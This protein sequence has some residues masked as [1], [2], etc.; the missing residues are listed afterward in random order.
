MY[1]YIESRHLAGWATSVACSLPLQL[2]YAR[3]DFRQMSDVLSTL[4]LSDSSPECQ[5]S[6]HESIFRQWLNLT[7]NIFLELMPEILDWVEIWRFG[8]SFPPVDSFLCHP[9]LGTTRD[10]LWVIVLHETVSRT[11]R[12]DKRNEGGIQY[13]GVQLF[14]HD[15]FK[16]TDTCSPFLANPSPNMDLRWMF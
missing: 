12:M 15:P 9:L 3:H 10:M 8:R 7:P 4:F 13:L 1:M 6:I 5:D 14:P 16:N 11:Y 2:Y